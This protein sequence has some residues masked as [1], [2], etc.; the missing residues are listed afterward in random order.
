MN[1]ALEP[2]VA[3]YVERR[4]QVLEEVRRLLIASVDLRCEPD[5]IDPDAA[6]FGTGLGLDS[7]D[8]VEIVIGLEMDLGVK[9]EGESARRLALRSVNALVDIVMRARGLLP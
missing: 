7:L 4:E 9:L 6:L 2:E 1:V 3:A 8:A 5:Q